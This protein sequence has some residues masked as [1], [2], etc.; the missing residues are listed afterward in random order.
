MVWRDVSSPSGG[1]GGGIEPET[2]AM[3]L[4]RM[5]LMDGLEARSRGDL[6]S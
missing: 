3:A 2:L 6:P 5:T 1:G 4:E